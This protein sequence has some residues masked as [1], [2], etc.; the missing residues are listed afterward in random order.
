M[1]FALPFDC[2]PEEA[3]PIE[4]FL[5]Y[6]II[7]DAE[8]IEKCWLSNKFINLYV[9]GIIICPVELVKYK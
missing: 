5:A 6:R 2:K 9:E 3:K 7:H 1:L 4:I 8:M